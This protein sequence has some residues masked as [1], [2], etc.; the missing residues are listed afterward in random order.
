MS[1]HQPT[2]CFIAQLEAVYWLQ[3]CK[4]NLYI[5]GFSLHFCSSEGRNELDIK[6]CVRCLNAPQAHLNNI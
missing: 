1:A 4:E 2:N 3:K 5:L 6:E